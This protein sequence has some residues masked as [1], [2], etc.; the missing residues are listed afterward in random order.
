MDALEGIFLPTK[1]DTVLNYKG[2]EV[3]VPPTVDRPREVA[4]CQKIPKASCVTVWWRLLPSLAPT[5]VKNLIFLHEHKLL[6]GDSLTNSQNL[7][8]SD[9][10]FFWSGLKFTKFKSS[11]PEYDSKSRLQT[12]YDESFPS[13]S[14]R[15]IALLGGTPKYW[16]PYLKKE[17]QLTRDTVRFLLR[18]SGYLLPT[19]HM[20][21]TSS[22]F[23]AVLPLNSK[24]NSLY[25]LRAENVAA[26]QKRT[27]PD[28]ILQIFDLVQYATD[29]LVLSGGGGGPPG[30]GAGAQADG[31][32]PTSPSQQ[33][34]HKEDGSSQGAGVLSVKKIEEI[35]TTER[36]NELA[37]KILKSAPKGP[38]KSEPKKI[39][40]YSEDPEH[41]LRAKNAFVDSATLFSIAADTNS[42]MQDGNRMP[43][44]VG[45]FLGSEP[46]LGK[47]DLFKKIWIES[48]GWMSCG[49]RLEILK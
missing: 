10:R 49:S 4:N 7:E 21:E 48:P 40:P 11:D 35:I 25:S 45:K 5:L 9:L 13:S 17:I 23:D 22:G 6:S 28:S 3:Q 1:P 39:D 29:D 26:R 32:E 24:D 44:I 20:W 27:N 38:E 12:I 15:D 31:G 47:L 37:D 16:S 2:Q 8:F 33:I 41:E 19:G 42:M 34:T 43:A 18:D 30:M 46:Q 36:A 14:M